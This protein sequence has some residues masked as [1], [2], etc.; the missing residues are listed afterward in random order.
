MDRVTATSPKDARPTGDLPLSKLRGLPSS[1]R[2]AL[3]ARR[4]TTCEQLLR[5]AGGRAG[6]RQLLTQSRIDEAELMTILHRADLARIDGLGAVFGLILEEL[7]IATVARLAAEDAAQLHARVREY[8]RQERIS[9]RS[10][11][12]EEVAHWV[13]QARSLPPKVEED[14][15]STYHNGMSPAC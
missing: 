13:A 15:A 9:R 10:P 6:R 14:G 2:V 1:L 11:T 12:P 7:D 8:N 4:I 5:V 3:K